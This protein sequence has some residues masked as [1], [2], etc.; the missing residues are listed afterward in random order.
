M[1][2]ETLQYPP[3][4]ALSY[5]YTL[6]KYARVR[7]LTFA[8]CNHRGKRS[9]ISSQQEAT[10]RRLLHHTAHASLFATFGRV[11]YRSKLPSP[12]IVT[13]CDYRMLQRQA[14]RQAMLVF[15]ETVQQSHYMHLDTRRRTPT[16]RKR[17]SSQAP[18]KHL[19]D[20]HFINK[21]IKSD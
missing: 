11:I 6:I 12:S 10:T 21:I 8:P 17:R 13:P 16:H 3:S 18:S 4:L 19:T 9:T 5:P 15:L 1:H 7:V 14:K 2:K 20:K